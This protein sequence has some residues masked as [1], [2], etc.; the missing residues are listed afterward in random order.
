MIAIFVFFTLLNLTLGD[1]CFKIGTKSTP[2]F[3]EIDSSLNVT[4]YPFYGAVNSDFSGYTFKILN[5]V[6][7]NRIDLTT[8]GFNCTE[9][10]VFSDNPTALD[11]IAN[12]EIHTFWAATTVT[13]E[14]YETVDFAYHIPQETGISILLRTESSYGDVFGN[15]V[16]TIYDKVLIVLFVILTLIF[17]FSFISYIGDQFGENENRSLYK[18]NIKEGLPVAIF[19]VTTTIFSSSPQKPFTTVNKVLSI[20]L[21]MFKFVLFGI[22]TGLVSV[23]AISASVKYELNSLDDLGSNHKLITVAN[24]N[25]YDYIS[26]NNL[27]VQIIVTETIDDMF[28]QFTNDRSIDALAYDEGI[29]SYYRD[30]SSSLSKLPLMPDIYDPAYYGVGLPKSDSSWKTDIQQALTEMRQDGTMQEAWDIY[31]DSGTNSIE[32]ANSAF[33]IYGAII[34][35][36]LI[37]VCI[38][39]YLAVKY[40]ESKNIINWLKESKIWDTLNS[41]DFSAETVE[42]THEG[43]VL[44]TF[45]RETVRAVKRLD[46]GQ[47][48]D[49]DF[50]WASI[51]G[52]EW[53]DELYKTYNAANNDDLRF[54]WDEAASHMALLEIKGINVKIND[55]QETSMQRD[56][57]LM[58]YVVNIVSK[59]ALVM[60][61][62]DTIPQFEEEKKEQSIVRRENDRKV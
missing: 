39:L 57:S 36:I 13:K 54:V 58:Q 55:M 17:I 52:G 41:K 4:G 47:F 32:E 38:I 18:N 25:P 49:D 28:E 7:E 14:R 46:S 35:S 48:Y 30:A 43:K 10:V 12:D 1:S 34:G 29:V 5:D 27:R 22:F 19:W 50:Y 21:S 59:M 61:I 44:Y 11:A 51:F 26:Q 20:F 53:Y 3:V 45:N 6:L 40:K 56:S 37:F 31:F 15:I 16:K 60:G 8:S 9:Y 24:S 62:D 2:P 33:V 42:L 23:L